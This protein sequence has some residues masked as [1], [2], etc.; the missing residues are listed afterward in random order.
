MVPWALAAAGLWA[1]HNSFSGAFLL[2]DVHAIVENPLLRQPGRLLFA[3]VRPVADLSFALNYALGGLEVWGYHA[4]NLAIHLAAAGTLFGILRRTLQHRR[5]NGRGPGEATGL[6]F[7]VA[8]FW[9]LHPL[10]TQSVTY[11]VQR[12]ESLMGLFYLV[13]LYALIRWEA[14]P[15]ARFWSGA[16]LLACALG[17]ATKASMATA[18]L[19]VLLYDRTFC[20]GSFAWAWKRRKGYYLGL[21]ATWLL[22]PLLLSAAP[23]W[24]PT[25]GF[26]LESVTPLQYFLTQP[27][28]ILHY[29]RLSFWPHPLVLDYGDWPLA[30][31]FGAIVPPLLGVGAFL[32]LTIWLWHRRPEIGFW[33]GWFFLTL[34]ATSGLFPIKDLAFE[35]RMYLPLAGV[36][37]VAVLTADRGLRRLFSSARLRQTVA[38]GLCLAAGVALGGLTIRRNEDYRSEVRMWRDVVAKRPNNARAHSNLGNKL[39]AE[40]RVAEAVTHFERSIALQPDNPDAFN[41]LGSAYERLGQ[42][43]K[44]RGSFERALALHPFFAQAA[45]NLASLDVAEGRFQQAQERL[46]K[47]RS[48][49]LGLK[50]IKQR[51]LAQGR[52]LVSR[53]QFAEAELQLRE[54]VRDRDYSKADAEL[55]NM[56]AVTLRHQGKLQEALGLLQQVVT[57]LAPTQA[58]PWVNLGNVYRDLGEPAKAREAYQ[59]ALALDPTHPQAQA[60]LAASE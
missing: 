10:Q 9:L 7:A 37:A 39:L 21:A 33:G 47:I 45:L 49:D 31:T 42:I 13:T 5:F 38:V 14:A 53:N 6:A 43:Q 20:S 12:A 23:P 3:S 40:G 41:N 2:D 11:I 56:L 57:E 1:Y 27:G 22:L 18:P 25:A 50:G 30:R 16:S 8:L 29:L 4:L 51:A 15:A 58:T 46:E 59:R 26:A 32:L 52:I 60:A 35:H 54:A 19:A 17:M 34:A 55:L 48:E 44:A 28:V 24:E 36:T